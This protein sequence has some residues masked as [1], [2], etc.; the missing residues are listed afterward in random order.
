MAEE[1]HRVPDA[2][3]PLSATATSAPAGGEASE[4]VAISHVSGNYLCNR[5][6]HRNSGVDKRLLVLLA[7]GM[8]CGAIGV[9]AITQIALQAPNPEIYWGML[10]FVIGL[11]SPSAKR[12]S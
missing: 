10:S 9:L 4:E 12:P 8:V 3:D 1:V 11:H 5:G 6:C 7:Q 2:S